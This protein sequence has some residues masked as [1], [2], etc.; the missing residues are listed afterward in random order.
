MRDVYSTCTDSS[1]LRRYGISAVM[2]PGPS[3]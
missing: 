3:V 2:E 1:V